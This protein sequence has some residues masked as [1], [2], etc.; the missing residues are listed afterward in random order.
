MHRLSFVFP[1]AFLSRIPT[2]ENKFHHLRAEM[3]H[4]GDH[5]FREKLLCTTE[6]GHLERQ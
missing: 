3:G 5:P 6:V 4:D 2:T 1:P